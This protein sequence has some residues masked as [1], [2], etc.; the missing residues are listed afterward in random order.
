MSSGLQEAVR[1]FQTIPT[2]SVSTAEPQLAAETISHIEQISSN[3]QPDPAAGITAPI[4]PGRRSRRNQDASHKVASSQVTVKSIPDAKRPD[5]FY[6]TIRLPRELW[7]RSGFG[8]EHRIQ[9]VW[10]GQALS[11][12]RVSE[13]GV[14][15]KTVGSAVVVLQSWKL[16]NLNLDQPKVTSG[17]GSLRLTLN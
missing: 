2:P 5:R 8:S 12:Q 14:K 3:H 17:E 16:G 13:G 15:P 10:T 9:I 1:A 7:D 6:T 4:K 11:I